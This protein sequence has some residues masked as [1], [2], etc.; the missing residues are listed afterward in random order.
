[1]NWPELKFRGATICGPDTA[2][3]FPF[4]EDKHKRIAA[5]VITP[6]RAT[7]SSGAQVGR[8]L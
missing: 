1:M 5:K 8:F 3:P 6:P 4:P 7:M 2:G